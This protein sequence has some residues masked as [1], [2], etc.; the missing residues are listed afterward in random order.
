MR[1]LPD[2]ETIQIEITNACINQCS[3]CTRLCG[4]SS[5][6]F[7][8]PLD[9]I[10]QAIDSLEHFP[11][12]IGIMGGEPLL[13]PDFAA[14][15]DYLSS[16]RDRMRCGLWTTLPKGKERYREIIANT[17][18]CIFLNDHSKE[19]IMHTPLLVASDEVVLDKSYMWYLIDKCWIQNT[20]SASINMHGGFFCEVAAAF[21]NLSGDKGWEI[22]DGWWEK[23]PKDYTEQIEKY[24]KMCG[25]AIPLWRRDSTDGRDDISPK[26]LEFLQKVGSPKVK[27]GEYEIYDKGVV[28]DD[29][30]MFSFAEIE[31]RHQIAAKYNLGML[32]FV[33]PYLPEVNPELDEVSAEIKRQVLE[34]TA[35]GDAC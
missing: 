28:V 23:Y 25:A 7:F 19:G 31:Y 34:R 10:M 32:G 24:C 21:A 3:N 6:P 15:C 12:R 33:T 30:K 22:K 4:H 5:K 16:R 14:I 35:N 9:Q 26:N 20:W 29:R 8:M 17:F 18:G 1:S 2:M 11:N 13:H 27:R